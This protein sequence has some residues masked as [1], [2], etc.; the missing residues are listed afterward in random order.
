MPSHYEKIDRAVW[1]PTPP[2]TSR[3]LTSF[4]HSTSFFPVL[5]LVFLVFCWYFLHFLFVCIFSLL[6]VPEHWHKVSK[7]AASATWSAS[8][9]SSSTCGR[10]IGVTGL[11][12]SVPKASDDA[13]CVSQCNCI[14][15]CIRPQVRLFCQGE[16][17]A[18]S[19]CSNDSRW[20]VLDNLSLPSIGCLCCIA[21]NSSYSTVWL[22]LPSTNWPDECSSSSSSLCAVCQY[23]Q[24]AKMYF[25]RRLVHN[26]F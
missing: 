14:L 23:F 18:S 3:P 24:S 9:S 2:I 25:S 7:G 19:S 13:T 10:A 1:D 8:S 15:C 11:P 5:R 6:L 26:N 21:Y 16:G 22:L 12:G 17:E 4:F 20:W